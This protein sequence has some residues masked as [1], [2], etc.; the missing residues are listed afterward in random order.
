MASARLRRAFRYP[1]DLG[2]DE[3]AREELDEEEQECVIQTLKLL[4]DR[5]NSEYSIIFAAIPLLSA[6]IYLLPLLSSSSATID[7]CVALVS[8]L[9]LLATAHIMRYLPHRRHDSKGK[10]RMVDSNGHT[11]AQQLLPLVNAASCVSLVLIHF[12]FTSKES[13]FSTE[14]ITSSVPGA[15]LATVWVASRVMSSVDIKDLETLRYNYKGA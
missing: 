4:N 8:V 5:R 2:D 3:Y 14:L 11:Q 15:M 12:V 7:R 9:S 6:A 13:W 1:D 10:R